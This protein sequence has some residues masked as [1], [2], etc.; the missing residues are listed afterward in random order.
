MQFVKKSFSSERVQLDGNEFIRCQFEKA[1]LIFSA[2]AP[3]T[4]VD[5]YVST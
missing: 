3:V 1:T 4:I 5:S 2:K